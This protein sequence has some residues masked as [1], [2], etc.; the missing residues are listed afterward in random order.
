MDEGNGFKETAATLQC[1][2]GGE[3]FVSV[4]GSGI[5]RGF[6]LNCGGVTCGSAAHDACY[7]FLKKLDDYEKG[8]LGVLR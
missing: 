3:H 7:H 6:C 5:R 2:H 8:K 1:V 4:K